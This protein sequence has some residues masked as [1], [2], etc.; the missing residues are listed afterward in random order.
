MKDFSV[1]REAPFNN[2]GSFVELYNNNLNAWNGIKNIINSI[3]SNA[4]A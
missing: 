3:N 2:Y 4:A 1:L